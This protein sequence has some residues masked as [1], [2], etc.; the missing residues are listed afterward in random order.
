MGVTIDD[1]VMVNLQLNIQNIPQN[2]EMMTEIHQTLAAYLNPYVPARTGMLSTNTRVTPQYVEYI[3]PYA[4]Y[5]Y[6]GVV[7]GPNIP[8][9]ENG[10]IVGWFSQP[11][12][13]KQPTGRQI[14]YSHE[15]HDRATHHWEQAMIAERGTE[16]LADVTKIIQDKITGGIT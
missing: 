5:M 9:M 15:M 16:F 14:N 13:S 2:A 6:E 7:Y 4:H 12:V 3:S 11:G 1:T 10:V 8:I